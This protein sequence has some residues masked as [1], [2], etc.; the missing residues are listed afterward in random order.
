MNILR[1]TWFDYI[2]HCQFLSC[3]FVFS[4]LFDN[5]FTFL[6]FATFA[7]NVRVLFPSRINRYNCYVLT[8]NYHRVYTEHRVLKL[9]FQ[10]FIESSLISSNFQLF[11]IPQLEVRKL[12]KK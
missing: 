3:N 5:G 12:K 8:D 11:I 6:A 7:S 10:C 9:I 4:A 1:V 2:N